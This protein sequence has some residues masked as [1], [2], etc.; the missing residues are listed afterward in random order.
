MASRGVRQLCVLIKR[1]DEEIEEFPSNKKSIKQELY[2]LYRSFVRN[3]FKSFK[4]NVPIP[5]IFFLY[6]LLYA[7]YLKYSR[8]FPGGAVVKNPP[9]NAGTQVR[10][11]VWQ[12]PTC[13]GATNPCA[14]TTEPACHNY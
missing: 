7:F 12:D 10:A 4:E 3:G 11:L 2:L 9:A 6:L 5:P 1:M 8:A 13:H 14:T